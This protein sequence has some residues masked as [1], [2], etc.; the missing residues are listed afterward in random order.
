[1][2]NQQTVTPDDFEKHFTALHEDIRSRQKA[3]GVAAVFFG[4]LWVSFVALIGTGLF[5]AVKWL[6]QNT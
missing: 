3:I 5:L 6:W 2:R 4:V 1:M